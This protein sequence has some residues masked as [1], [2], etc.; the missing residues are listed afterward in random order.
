MKPD[1]VVLDFYDDPNG[2]GLK[3]VFPTTESLPEVLKSEKTAH[4]L[5]GEER[6]VLRDEAFALILQDGGKIFRKFAC[7]DPGN[8]LLSMLYFTQNYEKLPPEAIKVAA[9]NISV[10]A[11]EFGLKVPMLLKIAAKTG[12]VRKR[13]PM[14][15]RVQNDDQDWASR[16]NLLSI[17]GGSDQGKVQ[18]TAAQ[19]KTAAAVVQ[20]PIA[21]TP[22]VSGNMSP[23]GDQKKVRVTKKNAVNNAG[24]DGGAAGSLEVNPRTVN[25]TGKAPPAR[26][27]KAAATRHALDS[28]YPLDSFRDVANA[29]GYFSEFFTE[30]DPADRHEYAVKTAARATELGIDLTPEL[31]RYGS[32]EYS[33]DVD[34]HLASRRAV[35]SKEIAGSYSELAEKRASMDPEE[36]AATLGEMDKIAGLNQYWGGQVK[37]PYWSTFGGSKKV[38]EAAWSW[39][40]RVGTYLSADDLQWLARN[41][42]AALHKHFP[43]DL[44]NALVKDPF[45]IFDSLPDDAKEIIARLAND[46]FDGLPVN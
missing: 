20:A 35:V 30:M 4:I 22:S 28:R 40:S 11:E 16:T 37:D 38:K 23:A 1:V 3:K 31:E 26:V 44:T 18:S 14:T 24:V 12:M 43:S 33:P 41:G 27:K 19:L 29:I 8:T 10:A 42:R 21:S 15:E 5:N 36:F 39:L 45:T 17:Q 32:T 7:V 6:S 34:A 46:R 25:V 9:A 13:D 2:E